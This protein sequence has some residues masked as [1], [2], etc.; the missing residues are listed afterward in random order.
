MGKYE[1]KE[2][3]YAFYDFLERLRESG[4]TNMWG[5]APYLKAAYPQLTKQDANQILC[6]WIDNYD[7]LLAI[8]DWQRSDLKKKSFT[9]DF[10][11]KVQLSSICIEARTREEAESKLYKMSIEELLEAGSVESYDID[12]LE[13]NSET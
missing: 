6:E 9:F 2:G 13:V 7:E 1:I 4:I 11:L 3:H 5:A 8:R 12:E 10:L